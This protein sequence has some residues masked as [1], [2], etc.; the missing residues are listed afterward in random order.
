MTLLKYL[1]TG[2]IMGESLPAIL[3]PLGITIF[4][5]REDVLA[6]LISAVIGGG[7]ALIIY[8]IRS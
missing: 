1:V 7:I 3:H 4:A 2:V 8:K 6:H 5:S